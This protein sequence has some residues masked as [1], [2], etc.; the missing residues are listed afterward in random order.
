MLTPEEALRHVESRVEDRLAA[1]RINHANNAACIV[2]AA[3]LTRGLFVDRRAF[4]TSYDLP[5]MTKSRQTLLHSRGGRFRPVPGSAS[6]L[7]PVDREVRN[8][9]S[10]V[11]LTSG[12][13]L[14]ALRKARPATRA[15]VISRWSRSTSP[16]G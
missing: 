3:T 1:A 2:D 8:R 9:V 10:S 13:L 16:S 15:P 14:S 11:I 7:L 5:V 4:L 6:V 12:L